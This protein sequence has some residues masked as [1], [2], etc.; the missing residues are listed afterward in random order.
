[1][2]DQIN[3]NRKL[4]SGSLYDNPNSN[5]GSK[6]CEMSGKRIIEELAQNEEEKEEKPNLEAKPM[7]PV[8]MMI[9]NQALIPKTK[10]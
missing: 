7:C 5:K 6:K 1:M 8:K 10:S 3:M 9:N 4:L 2:K